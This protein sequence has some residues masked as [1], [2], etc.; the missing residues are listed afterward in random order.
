MNKKR[1]QMEKVVALVLL[2]YAIGLLV[3]EAMRDGM[4]GSGGGNPHSHLE[5]QRKRGRSGS[6]TLA[7][8]FY[9][10]RRS[11]WDKK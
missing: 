11:N 6:S 5:S 3:G 4:Y 8:L 10:S 7:C 9:S 1:E 2:A